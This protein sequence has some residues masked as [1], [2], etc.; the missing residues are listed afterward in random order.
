MLY[1]GIKRTRGCADFLPVSVQEGD[2]LEM[3]AQ[4]VGWAAGPP[5]Q[6][7]TGGEHGELEPLLSPGGCEGK[8]HERHQLPPAPGAGEGRTFL[9]CYS[10]RLKQREGLISPILVLIL[11][12]V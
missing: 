7:S 10:V 4:S 9:T 1:V 5:C 2:A 11:H 6:G 8:A 3:V 12:L